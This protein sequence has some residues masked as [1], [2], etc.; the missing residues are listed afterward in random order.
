MRRHREY[1]PPAKGDRVKRVVRSKMEA[2]ADR[3]V[4]GTIVKV[5]LD[6]SVPEG[7][8]CRV[9]WWDRGDPEKPHRSFQYTWIR[10]HLLAVVR[11]EVHREHPV[12]EAGAVGAPTGR[13][14]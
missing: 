9:R 7:Y 13:N 14:E 11:Q 5:R 6:E 1:A 2:R 4:I 12:P 10:P 3:P 8:V